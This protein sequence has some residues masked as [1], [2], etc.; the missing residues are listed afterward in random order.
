MR[1]RKRVA[2]TAPLLQENRLMWVREDLVTMVL[3]SFSRITNKPEHG[4]LDVVFTMTKPRG[5]QL[6]KVFPT[7]KSALMLFK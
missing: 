6:F 7:S 2:H 5:K 3:V 1:G 4:R